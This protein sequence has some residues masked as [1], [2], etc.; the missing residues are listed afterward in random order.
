MV[1]LQDWIK[2]NDEWMKKGYSVFAIVKADRLILNRI[3]YDKWEP[4]LFVYPYLSEP[5]NDLMKE[6]LDRF[7]KND[8]I[9]FQAVRRGTNGKGNDLFPIIPL[10]LAQ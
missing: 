9:R 1:T 2:L 5:L 10:E 6:R 8:S 7:M 4:A 3:G